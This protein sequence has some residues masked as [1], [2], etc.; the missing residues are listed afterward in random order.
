MDIKVGLYIIQ[1][2]ITS[3]FHKSSLQTRHIIYPLL[4]KGVICMSS[5]SRWDAVRENSSSLTDKNAFHLFPMSELTSTNINGTSRV[6]HAGQQPVRQQGISVK[7]QKKQIHDQSL[8][9]KANMVHIQGQIF[10]D[11]RRNLQLCQKT[12]L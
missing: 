7:Q 8:L 12:V 10:S 9:W 3:Y 4:S 1:S 2:V 6:S 11:Y 5:D